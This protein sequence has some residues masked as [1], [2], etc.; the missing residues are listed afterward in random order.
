MARSPDVLQERRRISRTGFNSKLIVDLTSHWNDIGMESA[1]VK[2]A[3]SVLPARCIGLGSLNN[4][5]SLELGVPNFVH[6]LDPKL[7]DVGR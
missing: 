4:R 2:S 5:Q 7:N 6:I 3:F 1:K